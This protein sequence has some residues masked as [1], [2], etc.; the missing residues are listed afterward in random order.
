MKKY[1]SKNGYF[2]HY[3]K[4]GH[5]CR[6]KVSKKALNKTNSEFLIKFKK[7]KDET[8]LYHYPS[9]KF[10]CVNEV[11]TFILKNLENKNLVFKVI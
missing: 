6:I 10:R 5:S 4:N 2:K 1:N 9:K 3:N 7:A 8:W 11:I